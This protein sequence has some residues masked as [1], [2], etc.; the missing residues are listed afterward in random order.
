MT[1][2]ILAGGNDRKS[3]DFGTK[4]SEEVYKSVNRPVKILSCFFSDPEPWQWGLRAKD[5][6]PWFRKYFGDDITYEFA[7]PE[8]FIEQIRRSDCIFL[9][10][11]DN[12]TLINRMQKYSELPSAF[13]GKT[14]VGSSAGA[15]YLSHRYWTRSG[16]QVKQGADVLPVNVMVH[17]G[18]SDGSFGQ[19]PNDWESAEASLR[20]AV[21]SDDI[22]RIREGNF[23]I[24]E[25]P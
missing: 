17:C 2:Y 18:S 5:W 12:D 3:A 9:H 15:N 19:N 7:L 6:E 13:E 14:V 24:V 8:T 25:Q 23:T 16:Q 21:G 20:D 4:L 10:G 22:L 11:G 1:K